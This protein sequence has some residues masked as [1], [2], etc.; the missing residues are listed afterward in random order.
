MQI[1]PVGPLVFKAE[2]RPGELAVW[3]DG[4]EDKAATVP[5][6]EGSDLLRVKPW[7]WTS[8]LAVQFDGE[9]HTPGPAGVATRP[10]CIP[11]DVPQGPRA[12]MEGRLPGTPASA[13]RASWVPPASKVCRDVACGSARKLLVSQWRAAVANR[14]STLPRPT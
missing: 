5:V 12:P 3:L 13:S 1:F 9:H 8:G 11:T 7:M 2:R 14:R 6:K 4:H 10:D